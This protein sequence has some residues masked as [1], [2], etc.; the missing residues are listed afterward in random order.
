VLNGAPENRSTALV[1]T[2]AAAVTV[3]VAFLVTTASSQNRF[4]YA[5]CRFAAAAGLLEV[6]VNDEEGLVRRAGDRI[7][8][9]VP[10]GGPRIRYE[11]VPCEGGQ[12]T[13]HNTDLIDFAVASS[14]GTQGRL[15]LGNG[16][17]APGLTDEGDASSE[18]E[19]VASIEREGTELRIEAA[20]GRDDLRGGTTQDG[21]EVNL[22]PRE[23]GEAP[24]PDLRLAKTGKATLVFKTGGGRDL[25]RMNGGP[26][27]AGPLDLRGFI[28]AGLGP[29]RD[30][31]AAR[32]PLSLVRA[33]KGPD[34]VETGRRKDVVFAGP[35]DDRVTTRGGGDA[36]L[37]HFGRDQVWS[38]PGRD[39]VIAVDGD[40][41]RIHCG[42]GRD[43]VIADRRDQLI[44][45]EGVARVRWDPGVG[46]SSSF[47]PKT[48][49]S[50][51]RG[52]SGASRARKQRRRLTEAARGGLVVLHGSARG[53]RPSC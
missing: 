39:L 2:I 37:P 29:G 42:P 19:L 21:N 25:V 10:T 15:S 23:D 38:G 53:L 35:G 31:Y 30:H 36:I 32:L 22:N 49:G 51:C 28:T 26:E 8:V 11:T 14:G 20:D 5:E 1:V 13:V 18:I 45:C 7:L 16:P 47:G 9:R 4:D 41:D 33:G 6:H 3:T 43:R 44:D 34:A 12:A 24:D 50:G 52:R 17:F 46:P 40:R 48:A 27:F